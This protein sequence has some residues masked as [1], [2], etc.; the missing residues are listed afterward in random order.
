MFGERHRNFNPLSLYRERHGLFPLYDQSRIFQSTLPIQ[1]ETLEKYPEMGWRKYFNPLSLYRERHCHLKTSFQ[2]RNFNPLSLY[3]E[4]RMPRMLRENIWKI[5]IH[6]PYT[7]R[8]GIRRTG[9]YTRCISIHSPYT[10]RDAVRW[11]GG[12]GSVYFNPLSLYRE[13]PN[14]GRLLR[15]CI[16]Y[17]NPLS[18]YRERQPR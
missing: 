18:L 11:D 2:D 3:R 15:C 1:G 12:W 14:A 16:M 7:G 13:R 9:P 8:D 10:G 4:R 17:F 5:S 6:S